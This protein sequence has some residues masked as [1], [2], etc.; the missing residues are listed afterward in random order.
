MSASVLEEPCSILGQCIWVSLR[1]QW[2]GGS[3]SGLHSPSPPR[4]CATGLTSLLRVAAN[5][6]QHNLYS[7]RD[8]KLILQECVRVLPLPSLFGVCSVCVIFNF[9]P[10]KFALLFVNSKYE[11]AWQNRSTSWTRGAGCLFEATKTRN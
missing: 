8:S 1:T 2:H 6:T 5:R 7:D 11:A 10:Q 4:S 9:G 3:S